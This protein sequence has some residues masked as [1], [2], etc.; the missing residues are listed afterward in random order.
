MPSWLTGI[1][2]MS[3]PRD[4]VRVNIDY[5]QMGVGGDNSWGER[6]HPQYCLLEKEYRYSFR[7]VPLK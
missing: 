3:C 1:S 5:G 7:M 2:V 6:T 4:L